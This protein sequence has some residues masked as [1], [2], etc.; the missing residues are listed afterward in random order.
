MTS[1]EHSP[2]KH[3]Q[4]KLPLCRP[5]GSPHTGGITTSSELELLRQKRALELRR[6]MLLSQT[7]TQPEPVT[8]KEP[9]DPRKTV[10]GILV[11]RAEEVLET[12]RRYYPAETTQLEV[13]LAELVKSGSLKGPITGEELYSFLIRMGFDFSLDI[14]IRV[15]EHGTLKSLEEKFR[16]KD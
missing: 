13:R 8:K 15:K 3:L 1:N 16:S 2:Q 10:R 9:E 11:G 7:K 5:E 12:A 4:E 14:K 6:K